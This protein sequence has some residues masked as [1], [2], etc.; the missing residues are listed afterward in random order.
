MHPFRAA[1]E[2]GELEAVWATAL[3]RADGFTRLL[4]SLIFAVSRA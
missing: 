1:V 3:N 2:S 4:P